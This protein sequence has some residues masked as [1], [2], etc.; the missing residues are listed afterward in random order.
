MARRRTHDTCTPWG[1]HSLT[2]FSFSLFFQSALYGLGSAEI[3]SKQPYEASCL[4]LTDILIFVK[5]IQCHQLVNDSVESSTFANQYQKSVQGTETW[6][7]INAPPI[8]VP[9][10]CAHVF[11]QSD[12]TISP[13]HMVCFSSVYDSNACLIFDCLSL[14]RVPTA[15]A[16]PWESARSPG[17]GIS[18]GL[19]NSV[20]SIPG[21]LVT[22]SSQ[23]KWTVQ[24]TLT[25]AMDAWPKSKMI[26][27]AKELQKLCALSEKKYTIVLRQEYKKL[28]ALSEKIWYCAEI[29]IFP[30]YQPL[31]IRDVWNGTQRTTHDERLKDATLFFWKH[32]LLTLSSAA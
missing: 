16:S 13:G 10:L 17:T 14:L 29:K 6:F 8:L 22:C 7:Q 31:Y 28:C 23:M 12:F 1:T 5:Y 4:A 2:S 15:I 24:W 30:I 27:H 11:R 19:A 20:L 21:N 9:E 32:S 18:R 3:W 26:Q 25:R